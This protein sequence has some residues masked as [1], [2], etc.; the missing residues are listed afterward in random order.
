MA[1]LRKVNGAGDGVKPIRL[2]FFIRIAIANIAKTAK[3]TIENR[4][5]THGFQFRQFWQFWQLWQFLPIS[6]PSV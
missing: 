3:L 2:I 4:V 6:L 5:G 1:K